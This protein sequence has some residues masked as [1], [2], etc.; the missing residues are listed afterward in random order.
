MNRVLIVDDDVNLQKRLSEILEKE[1]YQT[2][3]AGNGKVGLSKIQANVADVV[4]LDF[5]LPDIDGI[6]VMQSLKKSNP[7][8][9]TPIIMITA[10]KGI[11]NVIHAMKL[12]AYDY[13]IKPFDNDEL[14]LTVKKAMRTHYLE[15]KVVLLQ[16]RLNEHLL[17]EKKIGISPAI[18]KVLK[19]VSLISPTNMNV[20]IQGK[21][22]TGKEVFANLIHKKSQRGRNS[23]AFAERK[24]GRHSAACQ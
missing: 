7:E 16:N 23:A 15:K 13:L 2:I 22:G 4:L 17:E 11:K 3:S 18:K 24:T 12:G 20:I 5:M 14:I 1:G 9:K 6:T 19:Q 8:L 21:S 10:Y